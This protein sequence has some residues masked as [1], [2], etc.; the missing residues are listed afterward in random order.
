MR[1]PTKVLRWE[2]P[3]HPQG[4]AKGGGRSRWE[5]VAAELVDE[6]GRW[7]VVY[8]GFSTSAAAVATII[9]F[10]KVRCFTPTG[11]FEAV[12]RKH[13]NMTTV[14]ARHIGVQS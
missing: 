11:S 6:S 7:A 10:G 12:T 5:P 3:P 1:V 9:R 13:K 2:D 4:P 8:E 14:Y